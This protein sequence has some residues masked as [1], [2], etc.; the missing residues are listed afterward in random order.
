MKYHS[1][2][3]DSSFDTVKCYTLLYSVFHSL[4]VRGINNSNSN[5]WRTNIMNNPK[6]D[7]SLALDFTGVHRWCSVQAWWQ[8]RRKNRNERMLHCVTVRGPPC[9]L[10]ISSGKGIFHLG[11]IFFSNH[12]VRMGTR[13]F[14]HDPQLHSYRFWFK[15]TTWAGLD[16]A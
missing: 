13:K 1:H 11:N 8:G 12:E 15:D 4:T 3:S 10:L 5:F 9:T 16:Q 6:C 7:N 2:P 14:L